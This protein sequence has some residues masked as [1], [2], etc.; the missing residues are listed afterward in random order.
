[1]RKG[2]DNSDFASAAKAKPAEIDGDDV[3]LNSYKMWKYSPSPQTMSSVLRRLQPTINNA[4]TSFGG[5][6]TNPI[7]RN[8]AKKIAIESI[9][10]Y[11]PANESS[12]KSWVSTNMQ[13]LRRYQQEL[14]PMKL[15]ERVRIDN[16]KILRAIDEF[17]SVNNREPD[18]D[19]VADATGISKKRIAYVRK[20]AVP[21]LNEGQ[22]EL[23]DSN[24]GES[25]SYVPGVDSNEWQNVWAEYVY[26]DLDPV[27]KQIFNMRLG[28]GSYAGKPLSVIEVA[29]KLKLSSAA[30]S[31][32]SNKIAAALARGMDMEGKI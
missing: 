27:D 21:V 17:K 26:N 23:I 19:E 13:G 3:V 2:T 20:L 31:Q 28:R 30:V 10:S 4:L 9:K 14:T 15:P 24:D 29:K 18:D 6:V 25:S 12:L 1:M 16:F 8:Y 22:F 5:G 11:D 7:M 32:R